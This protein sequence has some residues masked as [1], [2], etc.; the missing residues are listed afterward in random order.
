MHSAKGMMIEKSVCGVVFMQQKLSCEANE[1]RDEFLHWFKQE[2]KRIWHRDNKADV[3]RAFSATCHRCRKLTTKSQGVAHHT[4]YNYGEKRSVYDY[5]GEELAGAG[6]VVWTCHKCHNEIHATESIDG[7]TRM[8]EKKRNYEY[9][10]W[11]FQTDDELLEWSDK[12]TE[13]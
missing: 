11:I 1:R 6:V 7:M 13:P 3:C 9:E 4:T 8:V 2:R 10:E 5:T 12:Y